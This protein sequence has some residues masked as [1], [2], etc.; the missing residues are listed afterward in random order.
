MSDDLIRG[1][2]RIL[3]GPSGAPAVALNSFLVMEEGES[4]YDV[5][6][7]WRDL[8]PSRT[9]IEIVEAANGKRFLKTNLSE[10][11]IKAQFVVGALGGPHHQPVP[12]SVVAMKKHDD[13]S[14]I[15][16]HFQL[17]VMKEFGTYGVGDASGARIVWEVGGHRKIAEDE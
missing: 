10:P 11:V 6:D 15:A 12:H 8:G 17:A 16:F 3:V 4:Q 1:P 7:P 2:F 5:V 14:I 9:G 13:D